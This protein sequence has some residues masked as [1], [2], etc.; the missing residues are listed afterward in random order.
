MNIPQE[1]S[2]TVADLSELP[3]HPMAQRFPMWPTDRLQ[4]LAADISANGLNIPIVI[5]RSEMMLL[6]GRNRLAACRIAG[7]EPNIEWFEGDDPRGLIVSRNIQTREMTASQKAM[8]LAVE[9]PE[10]THGGARTKGS[11][12]QTLLDFDKN[13][14]SRARVIHKH[15]PDLADA[16]ISGAVR[17]AAALSTAESNRARASSFEARFERLQE[18]APDL[19]RQVTEETLTLDEAEGA[20][21]ER[22]KRIRDTRTA[23]I[24]AMSRLRSIPSDIVTAISGIDLGETP[25]LK[26]S[27][28]NEF[29]QSLENLKGRMNHA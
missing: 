17:F 3:V 20:L 21:A 19:A 2:L 8:L 10:A 26:V 27:E 25:T 4:E 24:A 11:S 18:D 6:D 5:W 13:L 16:V 1:K 12:R 15:A 29:I 28:I 7:I 9:Y 23:S 22:Q 14:L